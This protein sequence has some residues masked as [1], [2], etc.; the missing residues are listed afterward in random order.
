MADT[1][2]CRQLINRDDG[3]VPASIFQAAEILLAEAGL[4]GEAF[5]GQSTLEAGLPNIFPDQNPHIHAPQISG[6]HQ[7]SLST[8]VCI[9]KQLNFLRFATSGR[10]SSP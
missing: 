5:L 10:V 1:Q 7:I 6:S 8:P 4:L 9:G 3:G 2:C